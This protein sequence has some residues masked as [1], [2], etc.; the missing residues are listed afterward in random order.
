MAPPNSVP[1]AVAAYNERVKLV[2]A[3]ANA[4]ALAL[5]AVAIIRPLIETGA[6]LSLWWSLGGLALHMFSHY[7]LGRLRKA[8]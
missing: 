5:V 2:A 4:I 8:G 6:S 3:T 7:V 1:D